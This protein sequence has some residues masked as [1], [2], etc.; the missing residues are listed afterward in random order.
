ME[1]VKNEEIVSLRGKLVKQIVIDFCDKS[2]FISFNEV[3]K[4]LQASLDSHL[5]FETKISDLKQDNNFSYGNISFEDEN[6]IIRVV[7]F[8]IISN[9][10]INDNE[11][12]KLNYE[13]TR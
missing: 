7:S 10:V 9:N 13:Q 1:N 3:E 5:K 12:K 8:T 11:I 4:L 2:M 6:N